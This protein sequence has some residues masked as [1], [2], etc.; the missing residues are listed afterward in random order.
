[1]LLAIG[2]LLAVAAIYGGVAWFS[3]ETL[4]NN[5]T[6]NGKELTRVDI[7]F[8]IPELLGEYIAPTVDP[9]QPPPALSGWRYFPERWSPLAY[10]LGILAT[11]WIWGNVVIRKLIPRDEFED[12]LERAY[13]SL[14]TGVAVVGT[15]TLLLGLAGWLSSLLFFLLLLGGPALVNLIA[16]RGETPPLPSITKR[17]RFWT[18]LGIACAIAIAPFLLAMLL[19]SL[20]PPNDF[21]V[22]EYHLEGAKEFFQRGRVEMLPHNVYTSFPFLT[23]MLCLAEMVLKRDWFTG[24]LAGQ[25]VLAAFAPL[26]AL[27]LFVAARRWLGTTA[28]WFAVLVHLTCPW[29][30]RISIIAYAEGGLACFLFATFFAAMRAIEATEPRTARRWTL[31]TGLLAGASAGCKYPAVLTVVIP[32]VCGAQRNC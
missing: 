15:V 27:G 20:Q 4:Q 12:E 5:S 16:L 3:S 10:A 6:F 1:M 19:G 23:E 29:T 24:A 18:G 25:A 11:S 7:W 26:T 22:K 2:W 32:L 21:D 28:G 30:Y 17:T 8:A 9:N 13:W 31:L 14:M